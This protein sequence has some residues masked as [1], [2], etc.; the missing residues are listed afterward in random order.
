MMGHEVGLRLGKRDRCTPEGV[1]PGT[2][3]VPLHT[4]MISHWCSW[5]NVVPVSGTDNVEIPRQPN[6]N[7]QVYGWNECTC[8]WW[9]STAYWLAHQHLLPLAQ[10]S[11][12]Q[13]VLNLFRTT[14]NY[15]YMY[16]YTLT[17]YVGNKNSHA[18]NIDSAA[19]NN[20]VLIISTSN[21]NLSVYY[22]I[23]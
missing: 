21:E 15:S 12:I 19:F 13:Y 6:C 5:Q 22:L 18:L 16:V 23:I 3:Q 10:T 2:L 8:R 7:S 1:E 9:N 4:H 14:D 20:I 17:V 11:S